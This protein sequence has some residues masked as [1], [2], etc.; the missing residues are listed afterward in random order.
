MDLLG[1]ISCQYKPSNSPFQIV[2]IT[3][4]NQHCLKDLVPGNFS[5]DWLT[6]SRNKVSDD[7][8]FLSVKA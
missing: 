2:A 8:I 1:S 3:S 4:L 6:T 5:C 7:F